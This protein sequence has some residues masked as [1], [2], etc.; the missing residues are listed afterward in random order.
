MCQ[1]CL[2]NLQYCLRLVQYLYLYVQQ[3][4]Y[5]TSIIPVAQ[6]TSSD[7]QMRRLPITL[8]ILVQV[9]YIRTCRLLVEYSASIVQVQYDSFR[10]PYRYEY[11]GTYHSD[12]DQNM[13]HH[14]N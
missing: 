9:Q 2:Y 5:C 11:T 12:T 14:I 3:Y 1:Y 8:L 4:R 10:Y 6:P 13:E 7:H